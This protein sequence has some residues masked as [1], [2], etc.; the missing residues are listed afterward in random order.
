MIFHFST[1]LSASQNIRELI[2]SFPLLSGWLLNISFD[3]LADPGIIQRHL[4]SRDCF[5]FI[6]LWHIPNC[7]L[8][9]GHYD[10]AT[11]N[12]GYKCLFRYWFLFCVPWEVVLQKKMVVAF[13]NV[14]GIAILSTSCKKW[15]LMILTI[16]FHW[17]N[18]RSYVPG[19]LPHWV[20]LICSSLRTMVLRTFSCISVLPFVTKDAWSGAS[21][22]FLKNHIS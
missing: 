19:V 7:F 2:C 9:L 13:L 20:L 12:P 6:I 5:F 3:L 18:N 17:D 11:V 1:A 10:S 22:I 16:P 14:L 8:Y 21:S 4:K 15:S